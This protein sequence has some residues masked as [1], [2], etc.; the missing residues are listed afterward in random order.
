MSAQP[1]LEA[2]DLRFVRQSDA[3]PLKVL[4]GAHLAVER[5][6]VVDVFGPSGAGKT[7]LLRALAL[8]QPGVTGE[9]LLDGATPAELG[10]RVWRTRVALL[11]QKPVILKGTVRE[12]LR[13]PWDLKVRDGEAA[14]DDDELRAALDRVSLEDVSL[15][16]DAVR[17]S[18]GQAARVALLRVVL[19]AP[20]VLLLDEP[21]ASLDSD[22][23]SQVAMLTAQFAASGAVVRVRHQMPDEVPARR[24]RLTA[25]H[26]RGVGPG[27]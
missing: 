6:E 19:T 15:D 5:G 20:D 25:G 21:D 1:L 8:L 24:L 7:T 4:D 22:S 2:R 9:L 12:N 14:P 23:A 27:A 17:L 26:L 3:G 16:R 13:M 11:P 10:E 18:V